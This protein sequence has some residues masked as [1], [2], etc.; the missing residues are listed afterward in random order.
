MYFDARA[1]KLRQPGAHLVVLACVWLP[2]NQA[3]RGLTAIK[4]RCL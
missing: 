1:T 3:R 2:L 4:T